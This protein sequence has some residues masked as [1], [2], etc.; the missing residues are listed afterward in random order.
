[1][2]STTKKPGP[3]PITI[4]PWNRD[5]DDAL[6]GLMQVDPKKVKDAEKAEKAKGK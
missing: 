1:V 2:K 5:T 3:K 4:A 6:R